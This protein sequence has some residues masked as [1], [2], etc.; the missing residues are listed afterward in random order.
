MTV[1]IGIRTKILTLLFVSLVAIFAAV[2]YFVIRQSTQTLRASLNERSLSFVEL[3][4]KPIGDTFLLYKDGGRIRITQQM[5]RFLDLDPDI[6]AISIIDT[7]GQTLF[8]SQDKHVESISREEASSFSPIIKRNSQNVATQIIQPYLEDSGAH[9]YSIIY[10][11]STQQITSAIVR[12]ARLIL[13]VALVILLISLVGTYMLMSYFFVRPLARVSHQAK[14]IS[15]GRLDQSIKSGRSDEIGDLARAV[16]SM[17][18]S[19]KND[20]RKLQELDRLKS[21]FLMITSH[22]L[23]TPL[24]VMQSSV[25][26]SQ[27]I[28]DLDQLKHI[29]QSISLSVLRLR[30]FAENVLTISSMENH[31]FEAISQPT[32]LRQ[33]IEKITGEFKLLASKKDIAWRVDIG[34][35]DAA[36]VEVDPAHLRSAIGNILDNAIKFTPENGSIN[37]Q[38]YST[39]NK[40]FIVVKDTGI[41]IAAS[42]LPKLFTKFH[43]GTST[44]DYNYEGAGLGLYL[45]KLTVTQY[46]GDISAASTE[47]N[48]TTFTITIPM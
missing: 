30:L 6:T 47:G 3:A 7:S 13:Y 12:T 23:R 19:L 21:E 5:E 18:E 11:V 25:E 22:N 1:R 40:L 15:G 28:H 16:N 20:I 17:A 29:M 37:I 39:D 42:E 2:S 32:N 43:R 27:S 24:A 10:T 9:R 33:F 46:G 4:T 38:A 41:G 44:L 14:V 34:L 35:D 48:G 36:I 45:S 26:L 8:S 31:Q